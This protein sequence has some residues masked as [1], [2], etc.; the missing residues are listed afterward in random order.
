M[1]ENDTKIKNL[2]IN[3][4]KN[5]NKNNINL[6]QQDYKDFH[7]IQQLLINPN[8]TNEMFNL[9]NKYFKS[10]YSQSQIDNIYTNLGIIT[11]TNNPDFSHQSLSNNYISLNRNF[12]LLPQNNLSYDNNS[13]YNTISSDILSILNTSHNNQPTI[14]NSSQPTIYHSSQPTISNTV[15]PTIS[16]SIQPTISNTVQPALIQTNQNYMLQHNQPNIYQNIPSYNNSSLIIAPEMQQIT[17]LMQTQM[18]YGYMPVMIPLTNNQQQPQTNNIMPENKINM[19]NDK[20]EDKLN[21]LESELINLRTM[22]EVGCETEVNKVKTELS[23]EIEGLK[24]DSEMYID[25]L[26]DYLSKNEIISITEIDSLKKKL[27]NNEIDKKFL[28]N[29]LE[30][31][32]KYSKQVSINK[33][34]DFD[35]IFNNKWYVPQSPGFDN[36]LMKPAQYDNMKSTFSRF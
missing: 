5:I 36:S 9:L 10:K 17:P 24:K 33:N 4:F 32:K 2:F 13:I 11:D 7:I 8:N 14:S 12:E 28:M 20:L 15:Q 31:K 6:T 26:F 21:K 23:K 34:I 1:F 19:F 22:K 29:Y 16:N 35:N 25:L 30:D 27:N 18:V 3:V